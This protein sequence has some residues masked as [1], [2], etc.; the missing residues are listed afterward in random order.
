MAI[1]TQASLF[2]PDPVCSVTN[3]SHPRGLSSGTDQSKAG[4][5]GLKIHHRP[6]FWVRGAIVLLGPIYKFA[7]HC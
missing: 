6:D 7:M 1:R 3:Q 2:Q 4:C 5:M